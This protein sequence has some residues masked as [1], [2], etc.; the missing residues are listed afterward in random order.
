MERDAQTIEV[1]EPVAQLGKL[2]AQVGIGTEP[3]DYRRDTG[4]AVHIIGGF[5]LEGKSNWAHECQN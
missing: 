2:D 5:R 1:V 3:E 4:V